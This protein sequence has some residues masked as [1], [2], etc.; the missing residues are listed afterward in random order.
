[1]LRWLLLAL[2]NT[3]VCYIQADSGPIRFSSCYIEDFRT[4]RVFFIFDEFPQQ[5]F[6]KIYEATCKP[7]VKLRI[8]EED[9]SAVSRRRGFL[10]A[11]PGKYFISLH[12]QE[13]K[14]GVKI[15]WDPRDVQ[16]DTQFFCE[17]GKTYVRMMVMIE[18]APCDKPNYCHFHTTIMCPK[19][20]IVE[21]PEPDRCAITELPCRFQTPLSKSFSDKLSRQKEYGLRILQYGAYFEYYIQTKLLGCLKRK[22]V[23]VNMKRF[24]RMTLDGK[25]RLL[26]SLNLIDS[27]T[28]SKLIEVKN[29]RNKLAHEAK[30]YHALYDL[31]DEKAMEI[32]R[33]AEE[34]LEILRTQH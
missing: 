13:C 29:E 34:C 25:I 14:E 17:I 18:P 16:I 19:T 33:K 12:L 27:E 5:D 15:P 30:P 9:I 28:Y 10:E 20:R 6:Y 32:I 2:E 8:G 7:I 26:Y 31:E 3:C 22:G 11:A 4:Y 1:M 21:P 24:P 23:E